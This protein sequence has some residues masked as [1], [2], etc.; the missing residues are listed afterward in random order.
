MPAYN[1]PDKKRAR[2]LQRETGRPYMSC[3]T[4]VRV[5]MAAEQAADEPEPEA[6]PS[7][8]Q[9]TSGGLFSHT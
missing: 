6:A 9:P 5:Q 4:E 8:E 2:A 7:P 1:P 3:L